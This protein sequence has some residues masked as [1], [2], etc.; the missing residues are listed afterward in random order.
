MLGAKTDKS[1]RLDITWGR[2]SRQKAEST[3]TAEAN[4]GLLVP[5]M[6]IPIRTTFCNK[7][8]ILFA[9][10]LDTETLSV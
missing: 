10:E 3:S 6:P 5:H 7:L 1:H 4:V 9:R 8:G 2:H